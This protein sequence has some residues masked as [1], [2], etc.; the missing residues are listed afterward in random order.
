MSY[1]PAV[2]PNPIDA[3]RTK[4]RVNLVLEEDE[5][6]ILERL[7]ADERL[8]LSKFIGKLIREEDE[9]AQRRKR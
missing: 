6:E 7:A 5:R 9:R 2:P 3:K 4:P 1:P 8:S